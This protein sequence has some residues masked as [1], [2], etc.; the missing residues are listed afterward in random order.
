MRRSVQKQLD[1]KAQRTQFDQMRTNNELQYDVL[2]KCN[3]GM[4]FQRLL[5]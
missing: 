4:E 2:S 1:S 5:N 3:S